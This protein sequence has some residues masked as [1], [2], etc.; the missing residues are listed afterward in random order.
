MVR[1]HDLAVL[2]RVLEEKQCRTLGHSYIFMH[3][4]TVIISFPTKDLW[5]VSLPACFFFLPLPTDFPFFS[6]I[7][8]LFFSESRGCYFGSSRP[9]GRHIHAPFSPIVTALYS[10]CLKQCEE[11]RDNLV[12][13]QPLS[14]LVFHNHPCT[15]T[16]RR[17]ETNT[18]H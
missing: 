17:A 13:S 8:L 11:L 7:F 18:K 10:K 9:R 6:A 1:G 12:S 5:M 16:S 14:G 4:G 2:G 3:Q 15:F